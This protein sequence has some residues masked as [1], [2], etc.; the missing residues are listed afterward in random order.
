MT[1]P[2]GLRP[3]PG[4]GATS[5]GRP[6]AGWK[7]R[8]PVF[9]AAL[10]WGSLTAIGF[11]AVPLLFAHL[12]TAALAGQTAA[13]LF[14]AQAWIAIACGLVLMFA[15]RSGEQPV[16][17]DWAGGALFFIFAGVLLALLAE[18]AVAPRIVARENL[19]LWHAVGTVMHLVQWLCAGTVLWKTAA[20][21]SSGPS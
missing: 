8:V 2:H 11:V 7:Q 5:L 20:L 13:K 9:A 6:G 4:G 12:P 10:W 16:R 17:M 19:K 15:S 14:A 21:R 3:A 1:A 18:F